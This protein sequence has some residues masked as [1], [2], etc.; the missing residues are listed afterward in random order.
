MVVAVALLIQYFSSGEFLF[1]GHPEGAA[2]VEAST[3]R[4]LYRP[5]SILLGYYMCGFTLLLIHYLHDGFF[6]FRT[7]YLV[8][9]N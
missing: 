4:P 1:L 5:G 3:G 7:R 2:P 8:G 9:K 6:F